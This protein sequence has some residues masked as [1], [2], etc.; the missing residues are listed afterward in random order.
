[1]KGFRSA[2][3]TLRANGVIGHDGKVPD[4]AEYRHDTATLVS[5]ERTTLRRKKERGS[6]DRGV[7]NEIL[8]EGLL[9]HVGFSVDGSPFVLPMVFARIEDTLYLH[10]ATANRMLRTLADGAEVCVTVT[11]VDAVVLARS[12]FHHS[13]NY[14]SV[15]VFG[16]A[17]R[18]IDDDE[19]LQAMMALLDHITPGRSV[20]TRPPSAD[21]LRATLMV[22]LP[23]IEG[24]AKVRTG[25]P[26]D[27]TSDMDAPFWAGQIPLSI[28]PG[29]AVADG[30]L[31]PEVE[32]PSYVRFYP[33][34][35]AGRTGEGST[36]SYGGTAPGR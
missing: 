17:T 7:V 6:F 35:G 25:G 15:M 36:P 4:P 13:M 20:D 28:V 31:P 29:A 11:L 34:R 33:V 26:I 22:R 5:T 16:T 2:S 18:V 21:E 32:V 24:S 8:D 1:V 10:G 23:I 19:K 27:E 12:A 14:R 3:A 9:C 30:A